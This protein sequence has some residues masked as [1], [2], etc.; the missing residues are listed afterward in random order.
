MV[1][2]SDPLRL[3]ARSQRGA[4]P[5][6]RCQWEVS[7]GAERRLSPGASA[8]RGPS[9]GASEWC[10]SVPVRSVACRPA[11]WQYVSPTGLFGLISQSAA[12]ARQATLR[13]CSPFVFSGSLTRPPAPP[14]VTVSEASAQSASLTRRPI[15]G[16]AVLR[17]TPYTA[18][19]DISW[20]RI[21]SRIT[22]A[23]R[24]DLRLAGKK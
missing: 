13:S 4:S 16:S 6:A 17:L 22:L 23:N 15:D 19:H 20:S 21:L 5:I 9:P 24:K 14:R 1:A 3:V 10:R 7:P 8:E 18:P 2:I 12:G 11:R